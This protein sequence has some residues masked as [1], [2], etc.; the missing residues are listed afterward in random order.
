LL[1][2]EQSVGTIEPGKQADLLV[3][4]GNPLKRISIIRDRG[5][6]AG[7]IQA[8]KVVSGRLSVS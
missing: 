8:G 3:I 2:I 1:G 6:I 4:D 7:V 5:R